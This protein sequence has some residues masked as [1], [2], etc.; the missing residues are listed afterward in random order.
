MNAKMSPE[1]LLELIRAFFPVPPRPP[2]GG[3]Y[4][5]LKLS[6]TPPPPFIIKILC[7]VI[8]EKRI[9]R[10]T[11]FSINLMS[12]LVYN[13]LYKFWLRNHPKKTDSRVWNSNGEIWT[14]D[15]D[16]SMWFLNHFHKGDKQKLKIY[17]L[18]LA[19]Y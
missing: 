17:I 7:I 15:S 8:L 16:F 1:I 4:R 14:V 9:Q 6:C 3:G 11:C 5:K 2:V 12:L 13:L 18:K 19:S 10:L